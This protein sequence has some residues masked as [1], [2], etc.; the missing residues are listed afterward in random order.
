VSVTILAT[1]GTIGDFVLD[2]L[3]KKGRKVRVTTYKK[4]PESRLGRR[5]N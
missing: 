5:W 3:T 2:G 1:G 4:Q